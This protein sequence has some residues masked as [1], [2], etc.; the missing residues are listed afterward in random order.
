[1]LDMRV[2]SDPKSSYQEG[3]TFSIHFVIY[4]M[5]AVH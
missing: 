2:V 5:M 3:I 4:E 1:M